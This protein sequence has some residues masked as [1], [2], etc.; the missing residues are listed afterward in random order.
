VNIHTLRTV[1]LVQSIEESDRGGDVL[2]LADRADA[3]R[4]AVRETP[5]GPLRQTGAVFPRSTEAF[6]A[7]RADLLLARV[8]MRS[9]AVDQVLAVA[10]GLTWLGRAVLVFALAAGLALSALDGRRQIN[11]LS[12]PLIGLVAWNLF[13]YALLLAAWI[14]HRRAR[15]LGSG[16]RRFWSGHFYQ[17]WVGRRVDSLLGQSNRFNAPLATA[18][19]R[20]TSEWTAIVHPLLLERAKQ[21]LHLAAALIAVGLIVGLYIRGIVFRYEAGWES[22]FLGAPAVRALVGLFYGPAARL[23]GIGLPTPAGI[24]ALRWTGTTG[25]GEAASWIHLIALTAAL[26]IVVPRSILGGM[27]RLR[28]WRLSTSPP[29][30]ASLLGNA[31]AL[32]VGAA[33]GVALE[34]AS[35]IPFAY[36]PGPESMSGLKNLLAAAL[37]GGVKVELRAPVRYGEEE[38]LRRQ[39]EQGAQWVVLLMAAASTPEA[40]NHGAAIGALRDSL[41]R[42]QGAPPLL[43]VVDTG[44]YAQRMHG[45]ASFDQR[46][47]ERR[48]LWSEF[49]AGYGLRACVV[50][51]SRIVVGA[52][53][54]S[55]ARDVARSAL[56]SGKLSSP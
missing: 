32:L 1:L 10:A 27:A 16:S 2:P 11:I 47:A 34:N 17:R 36:E 28:L 29:L 8:R 6:L 25:G 4:T 39:L 19:R 18:L 51:L 44:P 42:I 38:E 56:W 13:V 21:L 26:Y 20:F 33:G 22:T 24:E 40:E 3:T 50:D 54:E 49:I 23:T 12:F 35:V 31:R 5:P 52:P 30:P 55:E 43:V 7:R 46:L 53:S 9:P 41:A 48:R 37:G 14:K 45:D 15:G